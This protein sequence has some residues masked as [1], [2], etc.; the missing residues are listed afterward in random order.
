[1]ER[2]PER[3]GS[4]RWDLLVVGGGITGVTIARDAA[5]R[6]LSVALVERDDFAA[7]T[8]SRSSKLAHGG[9]RYLEH[10]HLGLVAESVRERERL[11][12]NAPHLVRPLP[13]L[14]PSSRGDGWP[15]MPLLRLGLWLYDRFA[16]SGGRGHRM[17][18]PADVLRA[19][20]WLA[21][22]NLRGGALYHDAGMDD[23][24]LVIENALA[25]DAA[26]AT[27]VNHAG[28]T[29]FTRRADGRIAGATV[30]DRLA[31]TD[32]PVEARLVV[33]AAG[34]WGDAVAT[35]G[36]RSGAPLLR[37]TKG[38][39]LVYAE[40]VTTHALTLRTPQDRRV[41][42]VLPWQGLTL[43]GTTDTDFA[44]DPG[45]VAPDDG[46]TGYLLDAVN[47][48]LP[49]ARL[50]RAKILSSF[51]GIRPLLAADPAHPSRVSREH[52][53]TETVP[54]LLSVLGGK[55]TT[56]RAMAEQAVD[57]A[58]ALLGMPRVPC[59]TADLPL[60]G[61][62][63]LPPDPDGPRRIPATPAWGRLLNAYGARAAAVLAV[64]EAIP[65]GLDP[66]CPHGWR[67]AGEI[68]FAAREEM[69]LTLEDVLVRRL[70]V[71]HT[72]ACRGT[73]RA[74]AAAGTLGRELGW[75][76]EKIRSETGSYRTTWKPL[77]KP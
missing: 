40:P 45:A 8:S 41:F 69:A 10:A 31:G 67:I 39:H 25:A 26:G 6:G 27:L 20:P 34:P 22:R 29:G 15:P 35:L 32:I 63:P 53:V 65:G 76:E 68:A 14:L 1:M 12:R 9:L 17:L 43:I 37:P 72:T 19:E 28:V 66:I 18:G 33:N 36:G 4:R 77:L 57:R 52:A 74:D 70:N 13:F 55:F 71:A 50:D 11:L 7:G 60:P 58:A 21:G 38:T 16:G 48:A 44:G 75:T 2:H 42:F 51:A 23:A 73:C 62:V 54:G 5:L 46:D 56:A 49:G 47:A 30:R 61:G 24:R 59:R 3:L 64:A